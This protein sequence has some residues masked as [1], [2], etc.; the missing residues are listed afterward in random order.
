MKVNIGCPRPIYDYFYYARSVDVVN[1]LHYAYLMGRK[2]MR[3]WPRLAWWLLD[4]CVIN[5]YYL[6]SCMRDRPDQ[7]GFREE[8]MISLMEQNKDKR[9]AVQEVAHPPPSIALAKDHYSERAEKIGDCVCCSHRPSVRVRSHFICHA[10]KVHLC[11]G[12]CFSKY[13]G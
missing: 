5:T 4:A 8:L 13:H 7:L 1:Q 2:A 9:R 6:W 3:C 12:S 11:I 10:C